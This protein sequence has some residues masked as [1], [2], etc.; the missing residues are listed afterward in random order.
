V[1]VP[2]SGSV[3]GDRVRW[4]LLPVIAAVGLAVERSSS[5]WAD[6]QIWL[7]DLVVGLAAATAGLVAWPRRR[8]V[9]V[10]LGLLGAAW[11][12]GTAWPAALFLHVGVLVQLLVSYPRWWPDSRTGTVA[13]GA[14]YAT[15]VAMPSWQSDA[16]LGVLAVGLLAVLAVRHR[17]A[18][19]TGRRY[20]QVAL[21]AGSL[22]VADLLAGAVL[23]TVVP[24]GGAVPP[25]L[26][27]H[28]FALVVI[29]AVLVRGVR[30]P[31][32]ARVADLVVELG[33]ARSGTVRDAL[34]EALGDRDLQLGFRTPEGTWVDTSGAPVSVPASDGARMSTVIEHDGRPLAVVVHHEAVLADPH[35]LAA[36]TAAIRLTA[37]HRVRRTEVEARLDELQAARRRLLMAADAEQRRLELRMSEGVARRLT[38]LDDVLRAAGMVSPAG[39][40]RVTGARREL[41]NTSDDLRALARGLRPPALDTGLAGALAALAR[42]SP[43]PVDVDVAPGR[44]DDGVEATV[45]FVCA[46]AVA[47]AAKHAG[48]QRIAVTV[49][50]GDG[51]VVVTVSDDG[52]GGADAAGGTG[53]HGLA[54]RVE[55]MGGRLRVDSPVGAGTR[56][57]ADLPLGRRPE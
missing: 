44:Y 6:A 48:A 17:T 37:A 38:A 4:A 24:D 28:E 8:S 56:L 7:P 13:V 1:L 57:A 3:D 52:I 49:A 12:L 40:A 31:A 33:E 11:M 26:A 21:T 43:V 19:G 5:E 25:A 15:A 47:N 35:L 34:A 14:G 16:G 30:G 41:A 55:A 50:A 22:L 51:R 23:R 45:W 36:A 42:R 10:L 9:A 39:A 18:D 29:C 27:G 53:L 46:E 2:S 20:T 32:P 54:D